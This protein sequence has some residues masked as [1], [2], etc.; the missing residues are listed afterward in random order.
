MMTVYE[1]IKEMR[2]LTNLGQYFS[3]SFVSYYRSKNKSSGVV[4]VARAKLRP[5]GPSDTSENSDIIEPY[6]DML[7]NE[8]REFYHPTLLTF[9][10]QSLKLT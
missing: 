2:R 9:N 4:E 7:T 1:A 10:G 5:R 3:F 8:P 6:L